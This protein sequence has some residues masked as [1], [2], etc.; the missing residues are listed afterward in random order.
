MIFWEME[1]GFLKAL[2]L[3]AGTPIIGYVMTF[4]G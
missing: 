3:K 4:Q 1:N 2:P